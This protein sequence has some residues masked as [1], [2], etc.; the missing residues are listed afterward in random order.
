[1][2]VFKIAIAVFLVLFLINWVCQVGSLKIKGF[3]FG[4]FF[5]ILILGLVIMRTAPYLKEAGLNLASGLN[6]VEFE[7]RTDTKDRLGQIQSLRQDTDLLMR[8]MDK[9][10]R[11]GFGN[12]MKYVVPR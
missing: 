10:K 4:D 2:F 12:Q 7:W 11:E 9:F 1:M 5:L 6:L 3:W 8:Q